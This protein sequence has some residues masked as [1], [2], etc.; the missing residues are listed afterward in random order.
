M[1]QGAATILPPDRKRA[2]RVRPAAALGAVGLGAVVLLGG[3]WIIRLP[4]A[5]A[6]LRSA[7]A[8]R[9]ATASFQ[10]DRLDLA[11]ARLGDV[12]IGPQAKPDF[13]ARSVT[14][15][16]G[17]G[18]GPRLAGVAVEGGRLRAAWTPAGLDLGDLGKLAGPGPSAARKPLPDLKISAKN[19]TA[20]LATPYGPLT[21]RIEA[22]GRLTRDFSAAAVIAPTSTEG[23]GGR[24]EGLAARATA[25]TENGGLKLEVAADL[26]RLESAKTRLSGLR[27]DLTGDV[28]RALA[29]ANAQGTIRVEQGAHE[30]MAFSGWSATATAAASDLGPGLRASAWRASL[31]NEVARATVP[32][33]ALNG[34]AAGLDLTG[35]AATAK[36]AWR[37]SA[38]EVVAAGLTAPVS[39]EGDVSLREG[40]LS[41]AGAIQARNGRARNP[42]QAADALDVL[43]A[44]PA[45]PAAA[46]IKPALARALAAFDVDAPI[47]FAWADGA[48]AIRG[49]GPVTLRA[50]SGAVLDL[51]P[52]AD[53]PPW[54]VT[55]PGPRVGVAGTL[56]LQGGGLPDMIVRRLALDLAKGET[57]AAGQLT[58][59]EWRGGG[60][61]VSTTDLDVAWRGGAGDG[62]L[63]VSGDMR[64]TGPFAGM[65]LRDAVAPLDLD[66]FERAGGWRIA[67]RTGCL[68][69]TAGAIEA[70]GLRFTAP[71]LD[72]CGS[73]ADGVLATVA[74]GGGLGGALRIAPTTLRGVQAGER[75]APV[76][77]GFGGVTAAFAGSTSRPLIRLEMDAPRFTQLMAADRT[78]T[79]TSETVTANV[80]AGGSWRI[81]GRFTGAVIDD[82]GL[83][84]AVTSGAGILAVE[85]A[86]NAAIVRVSD[87]TARVTDKAARPAFNPVTIVDGVAV[88]ADGVVRSTGDLRL[89]STGSALGRFE[90]RHDIA[91]NEGEATV[92]AE[93]LRFDEQLQPFKIS[94]LAR[95]VVEN[96]EGPIDVTGHV[97]WAGDRLT[98]DGLVKINSVSAATA[99]LGPISGVVGVIAFDDLTR[100]TTPPGQEIRL[101]EINPG[102]VVRDGTV[103]FQLK[104]N[105][106]IALESA[107]FPFARGILSVQPAQVTIGA[108]ETRY[109]LELKDVD[110]AQL[111]RDLDFKDLAA[112][113]KVQGVFPLIVTRTGARI[114]NGVLTAAPGGGMIAYTGQAADAVSSGAGQVAFDA[115]RS[116]RYDNLALELNGDLDGEIVTGIRF[117]GVNNAPI[118]AATLVPGLKTVGAT[119]LP[120]RFNVTVRAPFKDIAKGANQIVNPLGAIEAARAR[121]GLDPS[122][123]P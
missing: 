46:A 70:V 34:V 76:S 123:V 93:D 106:I 105:G 85:P 2:W 64:L 61:A 5:D 82:P 51:A 50:A 83:P 37:L 65:A 21:A 118:K 78:L 75:P 1:D 58:I 15:S 8:E 29:A 97:R 100:F 112:T 103:R 3:A 74:P 89:E 108:A 80:R 116:F 57:T 113:G 44:T 69:L 94:E 20:D 60:A 52:P 67:A 18:W 47:A 102:V 88:I 99:G 63:S 121:K 95:G 16:F 35:D 66:I 40:R 104:E 109:T 24:I 117:Q 62:R 84:A 30:G 79:A 87:V 122:K 49:T 71:R 72:I 17:W 33:G 32:G 98:S 7:I 9:G 10:V 41:G 23:E 101:G 25:V 12:R 73:G 90:A 43:G 11:G 38:A 115:L 36:G 13:E 54:Q 42:A 114:E 6:L 55:L 48:G 45:G 81:D 53:A 77:L 120:F 14:V 26:A 119:G 110:V 28:D 92:R 107:Q 56:S 19:L 31:R 4:A 39:A 96:A 91:A 68:P 86:G 27:I 111:M 22:A 59:A